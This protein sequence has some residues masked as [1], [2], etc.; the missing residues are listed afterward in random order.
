MTSDVLPS[1]KAITEFV[2]VH[3]SVVKRWIEEQN[4]PAWKDREDGAWRS[5]RSKINEWNQKQCENYKPGKAV[6]QPRSCG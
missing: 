2:G 6:R 4:F 5:S 1:K 3:W